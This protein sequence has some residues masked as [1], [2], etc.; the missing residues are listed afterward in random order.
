MSMD[1]SH[2]VCISITKALHR[3]YNKLSKTSFFLKNILVKMCKIAHKPNCQFLKKKL[4]KAFI[5]VKMPYQIIYSC[6]DEMVTLFISFLEFSIKISSTF[7]F[8][9][10]FQE[11]TLKVVEWIGFIGVNSLFPQL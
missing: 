3:S 5:E 1:Q 11:A 7:L 10:M 8:F 2:I 4:F 9:N 6:N